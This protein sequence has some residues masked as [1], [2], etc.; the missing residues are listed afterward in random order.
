MVKN[1]NSMEQVI[2]G[3]QEKFIESENDRV[4]QLIG[5]DQLIWENISTKTISTNFF[6]L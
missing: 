3:L 2:I 6:T 1:V 5:I 4:K